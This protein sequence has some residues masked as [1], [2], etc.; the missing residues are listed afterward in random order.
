MFHVGY[1]GKGNII[2]SRFTIIFQY[3]HIRQF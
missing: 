1:I 3:S 2:A